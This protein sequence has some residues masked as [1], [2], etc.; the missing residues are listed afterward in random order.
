MSVDTCMDEIKGK[1]QGREMQIH[2]P[3]RDYEVGRMSVNILGGFLFAAAGFIANMILLPAP[4][5][6]L[7]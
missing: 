6:Q 7:S 5:R 1:E 3:Q 4:V 2:I